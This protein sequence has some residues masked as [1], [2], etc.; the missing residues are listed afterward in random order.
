MAKKRTKKPAQRKS[1]ATGTKKVSRRRRK[2]GLSEGGVKGM[3]KGLLDPKKTVQNGKTSVAGLLGGTAATLSDKLIFKTPSKPK[4]L[5]LG[6]VAG[7]IAAGVGMPGLGAGYAGG[8]AALAFQNGLLADN[9]NYA[10]QDV[11]SD[12]APL[13][14]DEND[15]VMTLEEGNDGQAYYRYLSEEEVQTLEEA[16]AFSDYT[17]VD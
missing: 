7:F 5:I 15:N 14:L 10:E 4:R 8:M 6:L 9:A 11:L 12:D 17:M 3:L 2:R 13:F 1:P 16:G